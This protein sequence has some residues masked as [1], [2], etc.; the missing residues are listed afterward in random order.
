MAVVICHWS[1]VIRQLTSDRLVQLGMNENEAQPLRIT[2]E[3]T[4][5]HQEKNLEW[6]KN[7]LCVLCALSG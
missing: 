7:H 2:T 6:V 4:E 5:E 1:V 3:F